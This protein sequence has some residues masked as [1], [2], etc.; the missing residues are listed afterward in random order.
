MVIYNSNYKKNNFFNLYLSISYYVY[1]ILK[2][3]L[4][5]FILL[6]SLFLLIYSKKNNDIA[7][8]VRETTISITYP[9]M[10]ITN[11]F[12]D[13]SN[14]ITNNINNFLNIKT[15]NSQLIE[16]NLKLKLQLFKLK[17]LEEENYKLK[18][19]L[20]IVSTENEQDYSIEKINIITNTSFTSK[21]EIRSNEK[22]KNNDL[23]IDKDG[24]LIGKVINVNNEK[25]TVLLITDHSFK[26]PA[27]LEK[28]MTKVI[29]NGSFTDF[30]DINYFSGEKFNIVDKEMVFTSDDGN[31]AQAGI[32]IGTVFKENNKVRV[33]IFSNLNKLD[34]VIILHKKE[35]T[36]D[37][38]INND[39]ENKKIFINKN[40]TEQII[41]NKYNTQ[42]K[43]SIRKELN[44][45]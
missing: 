33:K 27:I 4:F 34:Y 3:V 9:Y 16:Q 40:N 23:V 18:E 11:V 24:N 35:N 29:V 21:I 32:P 45:I 5:T 36:F 43:E 17:I 2:N 20:N 42:I 6:L 30:L 7:N 39:I 12:N 14:S 1:I 41:N 28:S 25:A 22:M 31:I 37:N 19:I 10:A 13:L 44:D 8:F 15:I 26:I 38:P